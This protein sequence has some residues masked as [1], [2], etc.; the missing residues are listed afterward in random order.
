MS[1]I[2]TFHVSQ[3]L[4]FINEK[5]EIL[6]LKDAHTPY[7]D[8]PGGRL[9]KNE[10]DVPLLDCLQREIREELGEKFLFTIEESV[11]A[12][13]S[14]WNKTLKR[15]DDKRRVFLLF[16]EGEYEGGEIILSDEHE[17]YKWVK[18]AT[19]NPIGMFK[20]GIEETVRAYLPAGRQVSL[21]NDNL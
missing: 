8:F 14:L 6:I 16:Y 20:P 1:E 17:S 15:L 5:Q 3:K 12:L 13:D 10:F 9:D 4:F 19:F 7:Y 21:S 11:V 2:D 18:I